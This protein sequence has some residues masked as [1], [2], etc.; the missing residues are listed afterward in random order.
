MIWNFLLHITKVNKLIYVILKKYIH[1]INLAYR[2]NKMKKKID[3]KIF[4]FSV[5]FGY[6]S[7]LRQMFQL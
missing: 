4:R 2:N 5:T 3:P 7:R 6:G 1:K